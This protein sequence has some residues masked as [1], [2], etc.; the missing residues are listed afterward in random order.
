MHRITALGLALLAGCSA[1][2]DN[3]AGGEL[4]PDF[5]LLSADGEQVSLSDYAGDVVLVKISAFW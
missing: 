4:A 5:T 2:G 1:G 3:L